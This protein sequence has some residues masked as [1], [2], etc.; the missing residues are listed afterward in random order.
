MH[1]EVKGVEIF[2]VGHDAWGRTVLEGVSWDLLPVA[3]SVGL[4]VIVGHAIY[5]LV[6]RK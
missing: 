1:S 3:V 5:R 6:R 2:R 4:V